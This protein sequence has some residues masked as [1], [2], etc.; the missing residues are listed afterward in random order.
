MP[1][2]TLLIG[3][4]FQCNYNH[5]KYSSRENKVCNDKTLKNRVSR[6]RGELFGNT[7]KSIRDIPYLV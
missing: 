2:P 6:N 7:K 1:E 5:A 3:I 4:Y